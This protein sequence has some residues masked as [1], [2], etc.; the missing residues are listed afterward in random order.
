MFDQTD[1]YVPNLQVWMDWNFMPSFG[2]INDISLGQK[3]IDQDEKL[4]C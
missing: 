4:F 1:N 2:S 3:L